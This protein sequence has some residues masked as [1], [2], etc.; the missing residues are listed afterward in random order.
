MSALAYVKEHPYMSG[1]A[2]FVGGVL[3]VLLFRGPSAPIQ[4]AQNSSYD[5]GYNASVVSANAQLMQAQLAIQSHAADTQ[6]ALQAHLEDTSTALQVAQL[7]AQ[8]GSNKDNLAASVASKALAV[9]DTSNRLGASVDAQAIAAGVTTTQLNT[10]HDIAIASMGRDVALAVNKTTADN[11]SL[12]YF[13]GIQSDQDNATLA[14]TQAGYDYSRGIQQDQDK[15][16]ITLNQLANSHAEVLGTQANQR[17]GITTQG[18]LGL[19]K[20]QTDGAVSMATLNQQA[21]INADNNARMLAART[22]QVASDNTINAS[23]NAT[24]VQ[25]QQIGA[26]TSLKIAQTQADAQF[27]TALINGIAS[28]L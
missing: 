15:A 25:T 21:S 6:A 23:N 5:A 9:S 22:I 1:G 12:N 14:L 8:V 26:D 27:N 17:L 24:A 3:L 19:T 4:Q 11:N 2:V 28:F 20:L 18:M 16:T 7:Q 13:R 10:Q